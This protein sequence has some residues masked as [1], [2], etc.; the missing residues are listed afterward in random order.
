MKLT[1]EQA[2]QLIQKV[3]APDA[4][5]VESEEE[6]D[7]DISAALTAIDNN[8]SKILKPKIEAEVRETITTQV[9]GEVFGKTQSKLVKAF[10]VQRSTLSKAANIEEAIEL[11]KNH[12]SEQLDGDK[13]DTER[14][15]NELVA[16]QTAEREKLENEWKQKYSTLENEHLRGKKIE[17]LKSEIKTAPTTWDRDVAANEILRYAEE[18]YDVKL[19]NGALVYYQ[20]GSNLVATNAA[21]NDHIKHADI[22]REYLEPRN[23][24]E[25]DTRKLQPQQPLGNPPATPP[26]NPMIDRKQ[27]DKL[28][29][30]KQA[31]EAK[32]TQAQ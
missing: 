3:V 18:K 26:K 28:V 6:S 9:E 17:L 7:F 20:K 11:A 14:K 10:G 19:E 24:W 2:V 15:Y 29:E 27:G 31:I 8:R 1:A 21:G 22:A 4:N 5:I 23:G 30:L 25:T 32:R 13:A 16:T 12:Y